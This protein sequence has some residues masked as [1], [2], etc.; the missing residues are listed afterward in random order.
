MGAKIVEIIKKLK[1]ILRFQSW[2]SDKQHSS[3]KTRHTF[4]HRWKVA[5]KTLFCVIIL[6]DVTRNK[7]TNINKSGKLLETLTALE[8]GLEV[9]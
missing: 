4:E 6:L 5:N 1:K 8:T 2:A 9:K 3:L 7:R